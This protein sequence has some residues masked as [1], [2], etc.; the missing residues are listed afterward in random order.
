MFKK[1]VPVTSSQLEEFRQLLTKDG[2]PLGK[3]L[4]MRKFIIFIEIQYLVNNFRP[5]QKLG[6]RQILEVT[7]SVTESPTV[8]STTDTT[9]RRHADEITTTTDR[10]TTDSSTGRIAGGAILVVLLGLL[11]CSQAIRLSV[12]V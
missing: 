8:V 4:F 11:S 7:P 2:E 10:R 12:M 9:T 1:P 3:K 5:V 6:I